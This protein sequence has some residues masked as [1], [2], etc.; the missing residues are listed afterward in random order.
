MALPVRASYN[1]SQSLNYNPVSEQTTPVKASKPPLPPLQI[2][3]GESTPPSRPRG[4][5]RTPSHGSRGGRSA[6]LRLSVNRTSRSP[7]PAL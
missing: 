3:Q 6:L 7:P 4:T 1:P 2:P 5:S